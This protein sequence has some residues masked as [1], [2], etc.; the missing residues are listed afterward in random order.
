MSPT[1][2]LYTHATLPFSVH[3]S[4]LDTK[5]GNLIIRLL[6]SPRGTL[7]EL[8]LRGNKLC[9][10]GVISIASVFTYDLSST[11]QKGISISLMTLIELDLSQNQLSDAAVLALCKGL[12]TFA[13]HTCKENKQTNLKV[14][15]LD[16]NH[17]GDNAA[18]CLATLLQSSH[19]TAVEASR[20]TATFSLKELSINDK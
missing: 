17:L 18:L 7:E 15:R 9:D 16:R 11:L 2:S 5:T 3:N 1:L 14:L 4:S 6:T 13:K 8:N 12:L 20:G 10:D 19:H